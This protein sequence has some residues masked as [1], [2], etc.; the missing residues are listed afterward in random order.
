MQ[1]AVALAAVRMFGVLHLPAILLAGDSRG[2]DTMISDEKRYEFVTEQ[3]RYT[4][5]KIIEAFD[6]F[7]KLASGIVAGLIWI[8]TQN[9]DKATQLLVSSLV[10]WLYSLVALSSAVNIFANLRAWWGYRKAESELTESLVP[11]P[12]FPRSCINEMVFLL[13]IALTTVG[14]W[15]FI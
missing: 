10:P 13:L 2:G 6:L 12:R 4:N 11:P 5:E 9:L 1:I 14:C 3:Q 8:R 15:L 7:V